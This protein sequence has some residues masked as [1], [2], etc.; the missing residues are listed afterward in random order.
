MEDQNVKNPI[1]IVATFNQVLSNPAKNHYNL[2][3]TK[4]IRN[5]EDQ[6]KAI[7]SQGGITTPNYTNAHIEGLNLLGII[8]FFNG[9]Y[10]T[11]RTWLQLSVCKPLDLTVC[12]FVACIETI[13]EYLPSFLTFPGQPATMLFKMELKE[14]L[15]RVIP[16][17]WQTWLQDK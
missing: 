14:L 13:H 4:G 17:K 10:A 7:I 6:V 5:E 15:W 2:G 11:Q 8:I 9:A 12:S 3:V 16:C 1:E